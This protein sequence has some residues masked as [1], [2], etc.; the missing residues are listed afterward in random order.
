MT[1]SNGTLGLFWRLGFCGRSDLCGSRHDRC[2]LLFKEFTNGIHR[3]EEA[4]GGVGKSGEPITLVEGDGLF[5]F[6]IN[7]YRPRCNRSAAQQG[8]LQSIC[9]KKFTNGFSFYSHTSRKPSD[10]RSR[11]FA[12][13]R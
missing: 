8:F 10:Q 4:I 13:F 11:H 3:Q 1:Q 2:F 9:Q 6:C 7:D 5:I 12:H